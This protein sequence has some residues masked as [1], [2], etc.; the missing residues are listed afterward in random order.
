MILE[1]ARQYL[2]DSF[3]TPSLLN[4]QSLLKS[5]VL[6]EAASPHQKSGDKRSHLCLCASEVSEYT[7]S[8]PLRTPFLSNMTWRLKSGLENKCVEP[9]GAAQPFCGRL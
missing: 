2:L 7:L 1:G 4:V 3:P 5:G 8:S 9:V 6:T